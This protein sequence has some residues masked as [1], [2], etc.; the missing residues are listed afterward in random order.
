MVAGISNLRSDQYAHVP[1]SCPIE[2]EVTGNRGQ[3]QRAGHENG[4]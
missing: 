4:P 3:P 1:Q 2:R